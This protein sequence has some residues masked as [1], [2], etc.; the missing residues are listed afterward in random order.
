VNQSYPQWQ[1]PSQQQHLPQAQDFP[2]PAVCQP[3]QYPV[4]NYLAPTYQVVYQ[5]T[6]YPQTLPTNGFAIAGLVL[7]LLGAVTPILLALPFVLGMLALLFGGI[8]LD[9]AN[10]ALASGKGMAVAGVVLGIVEALGSILL[11]ALL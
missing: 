8:G 1:Q 2:Q 3:Q 11:A 10:K 7:G 6:H 9:R 4:Q 5:Q